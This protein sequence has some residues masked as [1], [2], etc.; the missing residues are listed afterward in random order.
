[1]R[2]LDTLSTHR[3]TPAP[4]HGFKHVTTRKVASNEFWLST[5]RAPRPVRV[6][7]SELQRQNL[8][9]EPSKSLLLNVPRKG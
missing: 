2:T 4:G 9:G 1:M 6:R 3:T 5:F 7:A 8:I